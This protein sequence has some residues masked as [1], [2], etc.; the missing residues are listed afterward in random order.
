MKTE[1]WVVMTI[2]IPAFTFCCGKT[3]PYEA[4]SAWA[5][6]GITS[7]ERVEINGVK[8]SV[9]F[10]GTNLDNPILL[11]I[12]PS[13]ILFQGPLECAGKKWILVRDAGHMARGDKPGAFTEILIEQVL[14]NAPVDVQMK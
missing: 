7:L 13:G 12:H 5:Q 1:A 10:R 6:D 9:L 2:L 8:H 4:G 3:I 14:P 11:F